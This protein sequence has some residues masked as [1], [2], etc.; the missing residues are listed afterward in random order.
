MRRPNV[1]PPLGPVLGGVIAAKLGWEWIFWFLAIVGGSCLLLVLFTLPETSRL[2]VGDGSIPATGINRTFVAFLA[3]RKKRN[4]EQKEQVKET[5][6]KISFPNP[7]ACLKLL[8]LKDISIVLL[9]NG[10]YYTTYCC[11][12]A[13]LSTLF[14]DVYGYQELQAGLALGTLLTDLNPD[15]PS[16][17]AAS[18]NIVRCALAAGALAA[19]QPII[20]AVGAGWC[21]T[22]FGILCGACGPL[23]LLEMR[24][25]HRWRRS[26][27]IAELV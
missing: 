26:R 6:R 24:M 21:F 8:L 22:I 9:C 11:M 5:T 25:G 7:L 14:I 16:T 3:D 12:Q 20:D 19:L 13:S 18:A 17:A 2:I 27:G 15:K 10:I 1:A 23:L 4:Q